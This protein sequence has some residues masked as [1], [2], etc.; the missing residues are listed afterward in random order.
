ML[1]I[2]VKT[3]AC[4]RC[5]RCGRHF[6]NKRAAPPHCH[7]IV[8]PL[9]HHC[10]VCESE[11][12]CLDLRFC[13]W[14]LMGIFVPQVAAIANQC[15]PLSERTCT[16][17]GPKSAE[18]ET[19]N[20]QNGLVQNWV[21]TMVIHGIPVYQQYS[22]LIGK[23]MENYD[24]IHSQLPYFWTRNSGALW[25]GGGFN[26]ISL[27]SSQILGTSKIPLQREANGIYP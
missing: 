2:S 23:I 21:Y 24:S 27:R 20:G 12:I 19:P 7:T 16:A 17:S 8:T 1:K 15:S 3:D 11:A 9:S 6:R 25:G 5:G 22:N 4:E 10:D 13:F 26:A 18:L 14:P